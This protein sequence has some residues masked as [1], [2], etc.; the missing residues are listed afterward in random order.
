MDLGSYLEQWKGQEVIAFCGTIRYRGI[1]AELMG[2]GFILLT[3]VAVINPAAQESSEYKNC[4]L[5][6][7]EVS[8]LACEEVVG[9]GANL[10]D[11][12]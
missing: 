6:M 11:E 12:Y 9:R 1:L 2:G 7:N 10:T 8:G 5:N 4:V 3:G